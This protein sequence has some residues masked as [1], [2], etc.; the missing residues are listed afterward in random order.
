MTKVSDAQYRK[1]SQ[2]IDDLKRRLL[3]GSLEFNELKRETGPLIGQ[4]HAQLPEETSHLK[5]YRKITIAAKQR[6][7]GMKTENL[8]FYVDKD[9]FDAYDAHTVSRDTKKIEAY[10]Y[11]Q[12]I[13]DGSMGHFFASLNQDLDLVSIE[14]HEQVIEYI[15][16]HRSL[17]KD[18]YSTYFLYKSVSGERH[19]VRVYMNGDGDIRVTPEDLSDKSYIGKPSPSVGS[20]FVALCRNNP[21]F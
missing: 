13:I 7:K 15:N 20:R 14:T 2:Y 9:E 12:K 1:I 6:G 4:F 16:G 19:I 10:V 3:T 18:C 17:L 11:D 8:P 5:L 21:G